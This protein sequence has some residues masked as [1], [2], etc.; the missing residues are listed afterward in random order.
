MEVQH[1]NYSL[2]GV[3]GQGLSEGTCSW[4]VSVPSLTNIA[5]VAK[6]DE[7]LWRCLDAIKKTIDGSKDWKHDQRIQEQQRKNRNSKKLRKRPQKLRKG[8]QMRYDR[9]RGMIAVAIR[10]LTT[11][12]KDENTHGV[13]C[14]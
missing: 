3:G 6:G 1:K 8:T 14:D 12:A 10:P 11:G 9:S 2:L 7:L 5:P 4:I 13:A